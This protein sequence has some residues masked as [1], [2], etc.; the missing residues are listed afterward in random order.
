MRAILTIGIFS[1][2]TYYAGAQFNPDLFLAASVSD[3][4]L[5]E[6]QVSE[7]FLKDHDF[8]SPWIRE[9][10]IRARSNDSELGLEDY[11]LRF[12][13]INPGEIKANKNYKRELG[14]TIQLRKEDK[15][16]DVLRQ[17]YSLLIEHLYLSEVKS[18][19]EEYLSVLEKLKAL[20][21]QNNGNNLLEN[22][23]DTEEEILKLRIDLLGINQK[24]EITE[25]LIRERLSFSGDIKIDTS[26]LVTV[27]QVSNRIS[28]VS[29][30]NTDLKTALVLQEQKLEESL[31][32]VEKA[33][34]WRNIGFV[35]AEYDIERGA[36]AADHLGYQVG[37]SIPIFKTDRP[38]LQRDK[39]DLLQEKAE[40][41]TK[42]A[43]DKRE[44]QILRM[45]FDHIIDQLNLLRGQFDFID[46]F[47]QIEQQPDVDLI[48]K[49]KD[50]RRFLIEK[51]WGLYTL[52]LDKYIDFLHGHGQ[53]VSRPLVNHLARELSPIDQN[54]N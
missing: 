8:N 47:D 34:S 24:L 53:L 51:K 25:F 31:Y 37:V 17:R 32:N 46:K 41:E 22:A 45:D 29:T 28:L 11:R 42:L 5:R 3:L 12:G 1:L 15:I 38:D 10:E 30:E 7:N 39:I 19:S 23:L 21:Y 18:Y 50:Y 52:L 48:R 13:L 43:L 20:I 14:T 9:M 26:T 6:L 16:N 49:S 27:D 36:D 2:T 54:L 40:E 4:E 44:Q 33:E 35:Q